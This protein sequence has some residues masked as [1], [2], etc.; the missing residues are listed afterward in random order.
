[1]SRAQRSHE[2]NWNLA[3]P[4]EILEEADRRARNR[5]AGRNPTDDGPPTT[6]PARA[7]EHARHMLAGRVRIATPEDEAIAALPEELQQQMLDGAWIGDVTG[8]QLV[9]PVGP[10]GPVTTQRLVC[11]LPWSHLLADNRKYAPAL[12]KER[13][14]CIILTKDYRQAKKRAVDALQEQ[15]AGCK[16]IVG[17]VTLEAR[18]WEPD[19]R[20]RRDITNYAKLVHDALNGLAYLDDSL[21]DEAQWIRAGVDID[22]PRLE[23]TITSR[24]RR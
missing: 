20:W 12:N 21:I 19:R 7:T 5:L 22:R 4:A 9:L 2:V 10:L 6:P 23:L 14:P 11:E 24:L 17:P 3:S 18:F 13:R 8:D 1:M 16:P 15:L